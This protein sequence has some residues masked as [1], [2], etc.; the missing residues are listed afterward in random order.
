MEERISCMYNDGVRWD[1]S[2]LYS[3][4]SRMKISSLLLVVVVVVGGLLSGRHL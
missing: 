1:L 2:I 4:I 3:D